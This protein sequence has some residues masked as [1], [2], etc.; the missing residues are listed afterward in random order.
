MRASTSCAINFVGSS[1]ESMGSP[2]NNG[3]L[4]GSFC[5]AIVKRS[6]LALRADTSNERF[7]MSLFVAAANATADARSA[8]AS[9]SGSVASPVMTSTPS[10]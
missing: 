6:P 2:S 4:E 3:V 9:T 8:R 10:R 5:R 1:V 7:V